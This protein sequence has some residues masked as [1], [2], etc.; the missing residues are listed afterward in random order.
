MI[1]RITVSSI[2]NHNSVEGY[3]SISLFIYRCDRN[4]DGVVTAKE[5]YKTLRKEHNIAHH[6]VHQILDLAD[7]NGDGELTFEEF[8]TL[9]EHPKLKPLFMGAFTKYVETI[10]PPRRIGQKGRIRVALEEDESDLAYEQEFSCC[11]PPIGLPIMAIITIIPFVIDEYI[12][13]D[14]TL[15]AS[16]K[17]GRWLIYDPARRYEIWRFFTYMFVHIGYHHLVV[18]LIVLLVLGLPLEMVHKSW[19]VLSIYFAGVLAGSLATSVIDPEIKLGGASGGV[20]A[21]ITA[22]I[23]TLILNWKQTAFAP[24]QMIVFL[25]ITVLD[26]GAASYSRFIS[27]SSSHEQIGV[28]AHLAGAVAGICVGIDILRNLEEDRWE[29]YFKWITLVIF[30]MIMGSMIIIEIAYP[31]HFPPMDYTPM[32]NGL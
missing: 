31:S 4:G 1:S 7:Q 27:M 24:Y 30:V 11:P 6:V 21:I 25:G 9:I 19:R 3:Y 15:S 13:P 32:D 8:Q 2:L 16:G 22:H 28:V 23:S 10:I 20:Y 29:V 17:I 5:L 18:N 14:S 26:L 12:E